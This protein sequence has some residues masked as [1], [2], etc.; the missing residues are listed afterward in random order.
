MDSNT[1]ESSLQAQQSRIAFNLLCLLKGVG[2]ELKNNCTPEEISDVLPHLEKYD[3][4]GQIKGALLAY[5][6]TRMKH[7]GGDGI[8]TL[9]QVAE[10]W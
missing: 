8:F 7:S 3:N 4:D 10:E 2:I 1:L 9:P 6:N 5:I